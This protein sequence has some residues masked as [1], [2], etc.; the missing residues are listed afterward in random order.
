MAQ[1]TTQSYA[2]TKTRPVN[3]DT[4]TDLCQLVKH[5]GRNRSCVGPQKVFICFLSFPV[6]CISTK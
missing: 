4:D 5:P 6:V 3:S 1:N 2:F